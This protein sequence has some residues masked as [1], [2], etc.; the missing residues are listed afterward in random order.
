MREQGVWSLAWSRLRRD[1]VG[2]VSLF[3]V[4]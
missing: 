1:R 3:V 4:L 2:F